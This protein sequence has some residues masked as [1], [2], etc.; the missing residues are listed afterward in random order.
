MTRHCVFQA[1]SCDSCVLR[2]LGL[3][4]HGVQHS[5]CSQC[6]QCIQRYKRLVS[7]A[8]ALLVSLLVS[9]SPVAAPAR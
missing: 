4:A 5:Q 9:G 8:V 6:S 2:G 1:A 3:L 7:L